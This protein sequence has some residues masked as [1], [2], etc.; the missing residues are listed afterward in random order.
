[1]HLSLRFVVASVLVLG[2][3][4]DVGSSPADGADK[5]SPQQTT[6]P[7]DTNGNGKLSVI[8]RGVKRIAV[9]AARVQ[10]V[11]KRNER[12]VRKVR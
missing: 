9:G 10:K 12:V 2:A 11:L 1:M 7:F 6:R 4:F 3:G 8:E 5:K